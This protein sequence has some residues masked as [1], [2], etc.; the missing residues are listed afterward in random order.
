MWLQSL[1]PMVLAACSLSAIVLM[2]MCAS[3]L[4]S[5]ENAI[6]G[7]TLIH[8]SDMA[9]QISPTTAIYSAIMTIYFF[10]NFENNPIPRLNTCRRLQLLLGET[11]VATMEP[12]T[13]EPLKVMTRKATQAHTLLLVLMQQ[14]CWTLR[15]TP[16]TTFLPNAELLSGAAQEQLT[17]IMS[18]MF[19]LN[20]ADSSM[21][22]TDACA[23]VQ[24]SKVAT[25]GLEVSS[26]YSTN[27]SAICDNWDLFNQVDSHFGINTKAYRDIVCNNIPTET[28]TP[29][30]MGQHRSFHVSQTE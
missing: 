12:M 23:Q 8:T 18:A 4:P 14:H 11:A 28:P 6:P 30:S 3:E 19:A 13:H 1:L 5:T 26:D 9:P 21:N 24:T 10:T 17:A 27:H 2:P 25:Y 20:V 22:A 7:C 16:A 29:S 15:P